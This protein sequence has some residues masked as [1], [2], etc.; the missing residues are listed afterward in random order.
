VIVGAGFAGLQCAKKLGGEPVDVTIV[1][2]HN[3]HLFT[4]LLYQVAS[5]LLNPSE[6]TAPVRKVFRDSSNV[7]YRQGEV[8]DVDFAEQTVRLAHGETLHYDELVLATGST[9]NYY[10]NA[11]LKQRA[12]GLKDLGQALQLRNHV[13]EC[14][15]RASATSDPRERRRL[16]T[17]CIIGG[18]PTGVEYA[19]AL[20]ELVRLVLPHEYPEFPPSDVR[21]VLLEG[22]DRVLPAFRKRL[23]RYARR[24]LE[25]LGVDVRTDTLVA[26]AD[27]N[28]VITRDGTELV[29]ASI[30][31]TAGVNPAVVPHHPGLTRTKQDR[32]AVDDHLRILGARHAWGI[33]DVAGAPDRHGNPLPM[34]S[35][36]AMQA[37]RYV[38]RQILRGGSRRSFHY[39][40]K[41]TM[42][43]IGRRAAVA[44]I[45]PIQFTGFLGWMAWLVVH[46]Y[47]LIGFDNRLRVMMRWAWY[48]LRLDRPVRSILR[49]DP[50][51][52]EWTERGMGTGTHA[53]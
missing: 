44:Q 24:E 15:E 48:Y 42:A 12:L 45:G 1:D 50:P 38:A 47:Y 33:G 18:G 8:V 53:L 14:L 10:G 11:T 51:R 23:S 21:I 46:L 19:G 2:R 35:P 13:L 25:R 3:Y 37:G 40:D 31:W 30:V 7:R 20:A 26:S 29:T 28:G 52:A 41:G 5:C 27:E 6:I 36:P 39:I 16:L 34:L 4:P 43:T 49:A 22:G 32:L 9:T 17:F